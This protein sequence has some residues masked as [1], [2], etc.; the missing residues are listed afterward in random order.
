M[1]K[2]RLEFL[3]PSV[4]AD[5]RI[6]G[7]STIYQTVYIYDL[8]AKRYDGKIAGVYIIPA[9]PHEFKLLGDDLLLGLSEN[10]NQLYIWNLQNG[11]FECR[12]IWPRVV[13][14]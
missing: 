3:L 9:R 6:A 1:F 13:A 7:S 2:L 5:R 12:L 10:R 14:L 11:W 4:S 8:R